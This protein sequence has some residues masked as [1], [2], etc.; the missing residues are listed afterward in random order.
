MSWVT[1]IFPASFLNLKS[2]FLED[3]ECHSNKKAIKDIFYQIITNDLWFWGQN[4]ANVKNPIN[5]INPA[6]KWDLYPVMG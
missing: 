3:C 6:L 1:I 5:P 4:I 2:A